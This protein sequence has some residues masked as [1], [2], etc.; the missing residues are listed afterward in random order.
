[1]TDQMLRYRSATFMVRTVAPQVLMGYLTVDEVEDIQGN[2]PELTVQTNPLM[3]RRASE[4]A[5]EAPAPAPAPAPEPPPAPAPPTPPATTAPETA[6]STNGAKRSGIEE[7]V[8][9]KEVREK[10]D[11][12]GKLWGVYSQDGRFFSTRYGKLA[13]DAMAA[14]ELEAPVR[15]TYHAG[16]GG[17]FLLDSLDPVPEEPPSTTTTTA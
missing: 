10:E 17:G 2:T 16:P 6:P 11:T 4:A 15:I 7:V 13:D 14:A 1:M 8:L 9:V 12:K 3:P 5:A